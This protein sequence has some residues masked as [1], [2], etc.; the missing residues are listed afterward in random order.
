MKEFIR[1]SSME[2]KANKKREVDEAWL[3]K[4]VIDELNS[5]KDDIKQN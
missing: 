5:L 1:K 3:R 4:L 2:Q